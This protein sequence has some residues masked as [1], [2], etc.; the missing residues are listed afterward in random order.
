M[1]TYY[2]Y[3][4]ISQYIQIPDFVNNKVDVDYA[5]EKPGVRHCIK[6]IITNML[7]HGVVSYSKSNRVYYKHQTKYYTR[8]RMKQ[9][10]GLLIRDKYA[11]NSLGGFWNKKYPEGIS[12][13]LT[14]LDKLYT[15]YPFPITN[16]MLDLNSLP[17]LTVDKYPLSF[18]SDIK[19]I[20]KITSTH[21]LSLSPY[22]TIF[23]QCLYL[24]RHYFNKIKLDF[25]NLN[26]KDK[27]INQVGL[28]RAFS[29]GGCGRWFQRGGYSYQ[30]IPEADRLRILINAQEVN[31]L[32]YS[33]M[34]PNLMYAIAKVQAPP[35]IYAPVVQALNQQGYSGKNMRFVVK[36]VILKALNI[37]DYKTLVSLINLEKGKDLKN[38]RL[39]KKQGLA[40][41]PILYDELKKVGLESNVRAIVNAFK[42]VHPLIAGHIYG[43]SANTWMLYESEAMTKVLFQLMSLG[44]P[45]VPIHDSLLFPKQYRSTVERVMRDVYRQY[46]GFEIEVK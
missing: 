20:T 26:L 46:M 36:K 35:D 14:P 19:R 44:I 24:N 34:H 12:S 9:A 41:K 3:P 8:A 2:D 42:Q 37:R 32:D 39:R 21:P 1:T 33:A 16:L 11:L 23:M 27:H 31:E 38:N 10:V 40:P 4:F 29:N 5:S 25:S 30:H 28:H 13:R 7:A 17:V 18:L 43:C 22:G 45:A 6:L 15:D